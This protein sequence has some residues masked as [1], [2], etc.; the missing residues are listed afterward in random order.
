[1]VWSAIRLLLLSHRLQAQRM[2]CRGRPDGVCHA[3]TSLRLRRVRLGFELI[4]RATVRTAICRAI[5]APN[6][7]LLSYLTPT[8]AHLVDRTVGL[9]VDRETLI[10]K[11]RDIVGRDGV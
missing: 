5:R 6:P 3:L 10:E 4:A 7:V 11:L 1:M 9:I 2:R 8:P